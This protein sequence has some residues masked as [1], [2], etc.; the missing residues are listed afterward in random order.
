VN[1][2]DFAQFALRVGEEV[3]GEGHAIEMPFPIMGAEDFSFVLERVAGAMVFMGMK[4]DDVAEPAPNHSNRL[5][6][7][8]EGLS[9]GAA[10]HAAIALRYL[11]D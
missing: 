1:D 2:A 4:P 8:E 9:Y 6:L 3:L 10:L 11:G 5:L 7:N